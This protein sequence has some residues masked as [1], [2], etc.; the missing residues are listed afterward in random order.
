MSA[1]REAIALHV[2]HR[3]GCGEEI[4]QSD[5]VSFLTV[6]SLPQRPR[7]TAASLR[8]PGLDV[9]RTGCSS[10]SSSQAP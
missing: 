6:D 5:S 10:H 1:C 3:L 4:P 2:E 8:Q 7:E 9:N